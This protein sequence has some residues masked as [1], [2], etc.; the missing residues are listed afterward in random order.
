RTSTAPCPDQGQA[1]PIPPVGTST[2]ELRRS[3]NWTFNLA[4]MTEFKDAHRQITHSLRIDWG[5][6]GAQAIGKWLVARRDEHPTLRIAVIVAGER[7]QTE[8]SGPRR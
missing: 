5:P 4:P 1:V 6:T 8:A 7:G 3:V 2:V